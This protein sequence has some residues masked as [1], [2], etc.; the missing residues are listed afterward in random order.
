MIKGLYYYE[1]QIW[2]FVFMYQHDKNHKRDPHNDILT[3]GRFFIWWDSVGFFNRYKWAKKTKFFAM[4][5]MAY[6]ELYEA[7]FRITHSKSDCLELYRFHWK[8]GGFRYKDL[9][10]P[11]IDKVD[12]YFYK[13]SNGNSEKL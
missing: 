13:V 4:S 9:K 5:L 6:L 10:F 8:S 1:I 11:D 12:E 7:G 3:L 2:F